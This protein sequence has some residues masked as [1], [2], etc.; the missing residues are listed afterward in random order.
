[1]RSGHEASFYRGLF[2]LGWARVFLLLPFPKAAR[3]LGAHMQETTTQPAPMHEPA[4]LTVHHVVHVAA[5]HTLWESQC[6]VRAIAA[7][8]MLERRRIE[9]TLYLGT[10]KDERGN[11]IAHA[12]L[13]SGPFYITGA[14]GMQ[15]F[16]V[17]GT[18]ARRILH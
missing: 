18:F 13:R 4:L 6:L 9:S 12:W 7:L 10:A 5:L 16:V 2:F 11:M 14:E 3:F 17:V 8:K 1:M 15:R